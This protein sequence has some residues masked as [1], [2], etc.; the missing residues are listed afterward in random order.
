M[1][2]KNHSPKIGIA[3]IAFSV[4][5]NLML[6]GFVSASSRFYPLTAKYGLCI[7]SSGGRGNFMSVQYA[8]RMAG[9]DGSA[10][11]GQCRADG[12]QNACASWIGPTG[13]ST[14]KNIVLYA[15]SENDVLEVNF[16]GMCTDRS[17]RSGAMW[18][19]NA[20][21]SGGHGRATTGIVDSM[22][23]PS[24]NFVRPGT[25][26]SPSPRTT[27]LYVADFIRN[28]K[29]EP[30]TNNGKKT[31][32]MTVWLDRGHDDM[33]SLGLDDSKITLIIGEPEK[34][35]PNL[36]EAWAPDSWKK[37][38]ENN[39]TTSIVVKARNTAGRFG[40]A[41]SGAWHHNNA[42]PTGEIG[43]IYAM[44]TD[45]IEWHS[46]Y[47]P[48]IQ[49]TAKTDVSDINGAIVNGGA[50]NMWEYEWSKNTYVYLPDG[51]EN[52]QSHH[53][54]VGYK[55]LWVGYTERFSEW[56]N[57]YKVGSALGSAAGGDYGPGEYSWRSDFERSGGRGMGTGR[58]SDVGTILT[59]YASTGMPIIASIGSEKP[60]HD[61]YDWVEHS[62]PKYDEE[63]IR[64]WK[65]LYGID[66]SG[67]REYWEEWEVVCTNHFDDNTG[68]IKSASVSP[69]PAKDDATV[70]VPY[71][72]KNDTGVELASG[73]VYSG[74]S[75]NVS[76]TW[77]HVGTKYNNLTLAN[78]ATIVPH[79]D[80]KLFM[81]V[82][83]DPGNGE[84]VAVEASCDL[85]EGKQCLEIGEKGF[86]NVGGSLGGATVS[87]GGFN[88]EYNAFDA[89]AGD[90]I[91][92]ITAINPYTSGADDATGD[93][94]G[95]GMWKFGNSACKVIYKKPSFQVWGSSMYVKGGKV[96]TNIANKRYLYNNYY[97]G[98]TN[99][100]KNGNCF[101]PTSYSG[102]NYFGSWVEEGLIL[103]TATTSTL[104][105]GA[106]FGYASVNNF[107]K[108]GNSTKTTIRI[109]PLTFSNIMDTAGTGV[110]NSGIGSKMTNNPHDLI[111]YW[112]GDLT[113]YKTNMTNLWGGK[114][115]MLESAS[116]RKIYYIDGT[117]DTGTNSN[118]TI[119]S[120]N[121]PSGTTYLIKTEKNV[122]I[123]GNLKYQDPDRGLI[124]NVPKVVI[125]AS[126][127][128]IS[129]NVDE[130]DAIIIA[131]GTVNTCY[132]GTSDV[133]ASIRSRRLKVFGVV[134]ANSVKLERTYGAA[135]WKGGSVN[136]GRTTDAEAAEVFDYDSTIPMWSEFMGSSAE[137]DTLQIVYQH[138]LAPRY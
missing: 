89:S 12:G 118:I 14:T 74:E 73:N 81:Y 122:T 46:C 13:S 93:Y 61:I 76:N 53:P 99:L 112:I 116:G 125:Y 129:C 83:D 10:T 31:Y 101:K 136:G 135:A 95:D 5:L 63:T 72:F 50:D 27:E 59:Q 87:F 62:K 32:T 113:N 70:I 71:N 18:V 94:A 41:L 98:K 21:G 121:V 102:V 40:G 119:G 126:N 110:G 16:W 3:I 38:D 44:P 127:V 45:Y 26:G 8:C 80:M 117:K 56:Q 17:N 104:A 22:D 54:S 23:D 9:C 91:C 68:I 24:K 132:N 82:T 6:I 86:D 43:P 42:N 51:K 55:N 97:S 2:T 108:A 137:T 52:C 69:G 100:C 11:P 29:K 96:D 35:D 79:I 30:E 36:C 39:G 106:A 67:E 19:I 25:W 58:G 92:F 37:S 138:E 64:L 131:T 47:Y 75:V 78:Y 57:R 60:S 77:V 105:S 20:G 90:Y 48:G 84:M 66:L 107:E 134:V 4:V 114:R 85:I 130:V 34:E 88:G 109:S 103:N 124:S 1:M 49:K 128:D 15:A 120:Y 7:G 28:A 115:R 123:N 111:D 33:E 133:N 65:L